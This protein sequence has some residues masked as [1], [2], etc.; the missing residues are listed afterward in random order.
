MALL[1]SALGVSPQELLTFFAQGQ[2]RPGLGR[3]NKNTMKTKTNISG[4]ILRSSAA[5]V[6]LLS[7][8]VALSS[9][10]NPKSSTSQN[11]LAFGVNG[12]GNRPSGSAPS[13]HT[14]IG[15]GCLPNDYTITTG[16]GTIVP[17]TLDTRNHPHDGITLIA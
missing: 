3:K 12:Q 15:G 14:P 5:A 4:Y 10:S 13:T 6:L 1:A 2:S 17:G 9:A 7:V 16:S 11:N 8:V